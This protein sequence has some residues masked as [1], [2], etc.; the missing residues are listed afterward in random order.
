VNKQVPIHNSA[1]LSSSRQNYCEAQINKKLRLS[2]DNSS[3]NIDVLKNTSNSFIRHYPHL[4]I[5]IFT[6]NLEVQFESTQLAH[7]GLNF[8][9]FLIFFTFMV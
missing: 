8:A 6:S 4:T 2:I 3:I 7:R 5:S 1:K 9:D